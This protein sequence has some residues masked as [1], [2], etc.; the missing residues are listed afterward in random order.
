[1]NV[2]SSSATTAFNSEASLLNQTSRLQ[3]WCGRTIKYKTRVY[4]RYELLHVFVWKNAYFPHFHSFIYFYSSLCLVVVVVVFT[5][6]YIITV[7]MMYD[8]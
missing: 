7:I 8:I 2:A 6:S 1:M 3:L 4:K 5:C